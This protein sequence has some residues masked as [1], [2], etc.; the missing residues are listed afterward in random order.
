MFSIKRL[1]EKS[2]G[3][4]FLSQIKTATIV[5][6]VWDHRE[7]FQFDIYNMDGENYPIDFALFFKTTAQ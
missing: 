3:N 6:V 2:V 5:D 7:K 4:F 1:N